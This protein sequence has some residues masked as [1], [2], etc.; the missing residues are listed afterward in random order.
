MK[1]QI[2]KIIVFTIM[3]TMI[4]FI[5][6]QKESDFESLETDAASHAVADIDVLYYSNGKG[7]K[8]SI[9]SFKDGD[10]IN[11]TIKNLELQQKELLQDFREKYKYLDLEAFSNKMLETSFDEYAV[12]KSFNKQYNHNSLIDEIGR[13]HV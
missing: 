7:E 6:C 3:A 11:N 8:T 12:L 1:Q 4:S 10:I 5:S 13:A 2:K 9:L